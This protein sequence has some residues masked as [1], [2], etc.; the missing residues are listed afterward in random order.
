MLAK[1]ETGSIT[2]LMRK[3]VAASVVLA[4]SGVV[5]IVP[6]AA[7]VP[8]PWLYDVDVAVD[9]RTEAARLAVSAGA[10]AEVAGAC[11]RA[12]SCAPQCEGTRGAPPSRSLLQPFRLS[13]RRQIAYPLRAG[14]DPRVGG[15]GQVAG[16]VCQSSTGH[17]WLAVES[18]GVRQIVDGNHAL[19]KT[20][21]E[22]ARQRG[23]VLKL[24]LMTLKIAGAYSR[25]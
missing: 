14:G 3:A 7:A 5:M 10:L 25:P 20:L 4:L 16:L 15:R 21:K 23:V 9:G 19:A 6:A 2:R 18:A 12:C 1:E 8:V 24:P 22:R 13:R 17:G 11:Q